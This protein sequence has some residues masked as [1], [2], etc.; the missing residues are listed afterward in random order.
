MKLKIQVTLQKCY[1][2][3]I[4]FIPYTAFTPDRNEIPYEQYDSDKRKGKPVE[5]IGNIAVLSISTI[6]NQS[7]ITLNQKSIENTLDNL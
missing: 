5:G 6:S 2:V 4:H 7:A 3:I 1:L